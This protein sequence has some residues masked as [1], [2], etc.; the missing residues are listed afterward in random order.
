MHPATFTEASRTSAALRI[1]A[2]IPARYHSTRLPGKALADIAG[3]PMIEHVYR[4]ARRAAGVDDV[5]VATDDERIAEAV[6]RIRRH[7]R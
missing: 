1:V 7:A 3:R 5:I 6:R 2:V 4:R